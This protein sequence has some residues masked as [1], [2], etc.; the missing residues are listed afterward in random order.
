[1]NQASEDSWDVSGA[2]DEPGR[3]KGAC[4][5][6]RT[7]IEAP[8]ELVWDF[9]ADFEGWGGWNPLYQDT[10]GHAEEGEQ[11]RFVVHLSGMKPQKAKAQVTK[12][13]QNE[14]LEYAVSGPA[15]LLKIM[16]FVEIHE[17]SP[18]RCQVVNGEI[19]GG[20]LARLVPRSLGK[21]ASQGLKDMNE[22]LKFVAERKWRGRP[23]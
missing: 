11:I 8:P 17:L 10:L 2:C 21:K 9:I 14:L 16:R 1:M 20:P 19:M 5:G 23:V 13:R 12:V 18:T 6:H 15:G 4:L 3:L 22:A 7:T